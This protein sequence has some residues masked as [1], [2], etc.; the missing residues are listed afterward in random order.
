MSKT[1]IDIDDTLLSA[2]AETLGTMTKKDTVN[3]ALR[4]VAAT[5]ALNEELDMLIAGELADP[6]VL[7]NVRE[8]AWRR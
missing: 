7:A 5:R 1:L 8:R 3:G 4:A 2:A 6:G